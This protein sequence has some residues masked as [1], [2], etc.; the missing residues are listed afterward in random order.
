MHACTL[1]CCNCAE[2]GGCRVL[3]C[4]CY[5]HKSTRRR[6]AVPLP[7]P[8]RDAT[9][10]QLHDPPF[11]IKDGQGQKNIPIPRAIA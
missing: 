8:P 5:T 10:S 11:I 6:L 4:S 1:Y 7:C 3:A 2:P 9:Y